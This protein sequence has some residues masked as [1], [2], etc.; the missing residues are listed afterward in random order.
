MAKKRFRGEEF[1]NND[2]SCES[3]SLRFTQK[4]HYLPDD[5]MITDDTNHEAD[6]EVDYNCAMIFVQEEK[7]IGRGNVGKKDKGRD[8]EIPED[9][10]TSRSHLISK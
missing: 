9:I 1:I 7:K 2:H 8:I 3:A 5:T 6:H 4:F 10:V